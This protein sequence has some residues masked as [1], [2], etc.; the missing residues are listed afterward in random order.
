MVLNP[1]GPFSLSPLLTMK[2]PLSLVSISA[3]LA[4]SAASTNAALVAYW[5][6]N[7]LSIATAA[8]PGL[9]GVPTTIAATTGTGTLGLT[10]WTGTVDDFAGTA[11]NARGADLPEES[12]SLISSAGNGSFITVA[13]SMTLLEDLVVTYAHRGTA[14]GFNA[15]GWSYSTDGTTFTALAGSP[16]PTVN[17]TFALATADF[18]AITAL[19]NATTVTL[20][21]TLSGATAATGNNRIDN[22][23]V[24]AVPEPA[25]AVLGSLGLLVLLRRRRYF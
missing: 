16:T 4:L 15:G 21:Y 19:D 14:T 3:I 12:L 18:S 1:E 8:A 11:I 9:G 2:L 10:T 25:A 20:R 22:L 13:I 23:Q 5:N 24:N 7:E 17:T 6:F